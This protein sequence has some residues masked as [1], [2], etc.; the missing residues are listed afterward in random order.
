[1]AKMAPGGSLAKPASAF[2]AAQQ[3][4]HDGT[5]S[6][7]LSRNQYRD[8]WQASG[9]KSPADLQKF[10]DANGGTLQSGNGTVMTPFGEKI[11]MMKGARTNGNGEAA[12]GGIDEGGGGGAAP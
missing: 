6:A 8:M 10:I 5:T 3:V 11:D 4:G 1:A 12:W 7:G 2:D 9:A